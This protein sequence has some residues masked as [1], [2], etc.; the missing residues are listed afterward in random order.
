MRLHL[1]FHLEGSFEMPINYNYYLMAAIYNFLSIISMKY[2]TRLKMLGY[3]FGKRQYRNFVFSRLF[4]KREIKNSQIIFFNE[5]QW[6][7]SSV[8]DEFI[9]ILV[10]ALVKQET[11]NI[12]GKELQLKQVA[13]QRESKFTGS[14]AKF[15]TMSPIVLSK[16]VEGK[17][18]AYYLRRKDAEFGE[19]LKNNL[20]HKYVSYYQKEPDD[21][22]FNF[23]WLE[24]GLK[25]NGKLLEIKNG[26]KVYGSIGKFRI[27]GNPELIKFGYNTGF[28]EKN[29]IGFGMAE[30]V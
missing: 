13:V 30:K 5:I 17:N 8:S 18:T 24:D 12:K 11:L 6:Y 7:I 10:E 2:A 1:K 15:K 3:T 16:S 4:G 14:P 25:K 19:Y 23:E 21:R 9:R 28:G 26:I 22:I 27:A 20:I 29:S